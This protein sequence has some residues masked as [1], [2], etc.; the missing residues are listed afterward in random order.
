VDD[1]TGD[2]NGAVSIHRD[3]DVVYPPETATCGQRL[4]RVAGLGRL[5]DITYR[6]PSKF[7]RT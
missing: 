5:S 4:L 3:L 2:G 7:K 6:H 1:P